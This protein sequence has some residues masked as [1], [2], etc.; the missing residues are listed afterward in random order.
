M[1]HSIYLQIIHQHTGTGPECIYPS[2]MG[3]L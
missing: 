3:W 1:R 2:Q